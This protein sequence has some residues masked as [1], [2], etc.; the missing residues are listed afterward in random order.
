MQFN[1]WLPLPAHASFFVAN[2]CFPL[3][4]HAYWGFLALKYNYCLNFCFLF[5]HFKKKQYLCTRNGF[6]YP[7]I[8]SLP[9][10]RCSVPRT[11]LLW[12]THWRPASLRLSRRRAH[13]SARKGG[14]FFYM[15]RMLSHHMSFPQNRH[16]YPPPP[17]TGTREAQMERLRL[18]ERAKRY[19]NAAS[20]GTREE[21]MARRRL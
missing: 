12:G 13:L 1:G 21:Q 15:K 11:P 5:W 10:I 20:S 6:E 18:L 2:V 16:Y 14:P 19:W 3:L 8:F 17:T 4:N 9:Q 7:H